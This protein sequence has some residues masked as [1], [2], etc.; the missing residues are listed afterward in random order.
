[1]LL[2]YPRHIAALYR[3]SNKSARSASSIGTQAWMGG[4]LS[5]HGAAC[6]SWLATLMSTS[7][8]P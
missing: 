7:S 6:S 8:R 2:A 4:S 1:M 5:A 3:E